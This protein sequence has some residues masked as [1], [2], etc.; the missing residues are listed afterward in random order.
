[1]KR[2]QAAAVVGGMPEFVRWWKSRWPCQEDRKKF[3][4]EANTI[5][6]IRQDKVT[7]PSYNQHWGTIVVRTF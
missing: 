6:A 3:N 2:I 5:K 7:K 4:S 1:M